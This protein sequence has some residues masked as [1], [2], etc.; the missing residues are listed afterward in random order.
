[1]LKM[2]TKDGV[3]VVTENGR[4]EIE[5]TISDALQYVEHRRLLANVHGQS[6]TTRV[7]KTYFVRSLIP[8]TRKKTVTLYILDEE[9]V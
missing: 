6:T 1:M 7:D 8:P 9:A 2:H 4:V 5:G 3:T